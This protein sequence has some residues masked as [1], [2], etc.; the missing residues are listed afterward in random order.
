MAD[1]LLNLLSCRGIRDFHSG[2]F[3]LNFIALP[4]DN[5]MRYQHTEDL[6]QEPQEID[7]II[8]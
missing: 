3:V 4:S 1:F 2:R 7:K 5:Q 6:L 8:R